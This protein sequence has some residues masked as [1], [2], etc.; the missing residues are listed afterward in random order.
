MILWN[1]APGVG[2]P[3][4]AESAA[5][6]ALATLPGIT[7]QP[8]IKDT[9]GGQAIGI[10]DD[11]GYDQLLIDPV[12]FHVIGI[13]NISAGIAISA[14]LKEPAKGTLMEEIVFAQNIEVAAP[15]DR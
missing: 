5:Y 11:G 8:G 7:V 2:G 14:A 12:S 15:G 3:P 4:A 9:A 6:R 13:R 1:A 10:S